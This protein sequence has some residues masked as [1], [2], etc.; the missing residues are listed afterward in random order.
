MIVREKKTMKNKKKI[1]SC[2]SLLAFAALAA[3]FAGAG[4]R[5]NAAETAGETQKANGFYMEAGASVRIDGKAG[6]RFQAYLSADKYAELIE[7]PR[8]AGKDVK[9][10]AVANRSDT[11]ATLGATN[12]V[13][14]EVSL[15]LPDENGGYTLQARVTYDELAAD[16]IKKAAAVEISA[17]YYIVTDGEEQ[18]AVAAEEDDNSRSMRAVANAALTKGEVT[19]SAVKNYLGN[20]TNVSAAGKMYVSD[21]QTID[22]SGVIGNDVSA[23]TI[24][25]ISA[26]RK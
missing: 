23:V 21:M 8:Q 15:P 22:L 4:V 16:T 18:S 17:R 20:V 9:I 6:V 26:Q 19:E 24:R 13:R 7:T 11:G 25:R 1:L 12:A 5:A 14:Q 3:G 2:I 10:Y